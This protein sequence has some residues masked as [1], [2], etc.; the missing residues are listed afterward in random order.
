MCD[1]LTKLTLFF[2]RL[3]LLHP[4]GISLPVAEGLLTH[5]SAMFAVVFQ[6]KLQWDTNK[7]QHK[8]LINIILY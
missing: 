2:G 1:A 5:V 4:L 8:D 3:D 6:Q 7:K